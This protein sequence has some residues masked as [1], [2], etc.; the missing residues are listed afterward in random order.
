MKNRIFISIFF[1]VLLSACTK[2]KKLSCIP[3]H[4]H[5]DYLQKTPLFKALS[6]TF[7]SIEADI[8]KVG[9]SLFVAHD[10]DKIQQG[11]TLRQLYL[12]PLQK[13]LSNHPIDYELFILVDIK[14]EGKNV[15]PTLE[16][17]L[18]SYKDILTHYENG[19]VIEKSVRVILSGD[20]PT[21]LMLQREKRYTFLD[22]EISK[23]GKPFAKNLIPL[24]SGDW[25]N[26][27]KWK[28]LG[29]MPASEKQEL[30]KLVMKAKKQNAFLRFWNTPNASLEQRDNLRE[31]LSKY[32]NVI[33]G[34]DNIDEMALFFI[35]KDKQKMIVG[36]LKI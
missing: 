26:Y 15:Y 6:K 21:E 1:L 7:K 2:S 12:A 35:K 23:M 14:R 28:G 32:E 18:E 33:I 34:A 31:L 3:A 36:N 20:R 13:Q 24:Y 30:Q 4:S 5:N 9:D 16:V 8:Y 27:F 17:I 19:K 10:F 11:H 29:S 22:G 25:E